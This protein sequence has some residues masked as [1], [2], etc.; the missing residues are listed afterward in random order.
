MSNVPQYKLSVS[1]TNLG[2]RSHNTGSNL[3]EKGK[4]RLV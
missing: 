2:N 1:Q 3:I 4:K